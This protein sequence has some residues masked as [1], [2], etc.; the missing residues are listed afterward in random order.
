VRCSLSDLKFGVFDHLDRGGRSLADLYDARL[1]IVEQFDAAGFYGY[2]LAEHHSTP[3][4]MAPS[5]SVFLSAVAQRTKRIRLGPLVYLLPLYHPIRL[6]EEIAMLD[7]LSHGRLDVGIGRGRSPIELS[8][9]GRDAAEAQSVFDEALEILR[10]A[11]SERTVTFSG[12]HF[13]FQ[14]VPVELRPVQTPH[15]PFWYGVGSSESARTCGSLGFNVV[16]LAK[17]AVAADIARAF[18]DGAQSAGFRDKKMGL[19][20][21]VIVGETD[22]EAQD[23]ANRVYPVWHESFYELFRRY[24]QKP[25][26][27]WSNRFDE[28]AANGLAFAGSAQTVRAA[29][30]SQLDETGANY[31]VGQFVFGDMTRSESRRSVRLFTE[32]VMPELHAVGRKDQAAVTT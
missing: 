28:M 22:R 4:G 21:F 11:F 30:Q 23:L 25:V 8:L 12:R 20:R 24:G 6:A 9:Y 5:P 15:P 14:N 27:S 17:P 18:F 2:H 26:Q 10:I 32:R 3:L 7:H 29:I 19:A 13:E 1:E 31:V 16:A